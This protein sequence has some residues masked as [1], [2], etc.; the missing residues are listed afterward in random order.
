MVICIQQVA[1][2]VTS[3]IDLFFKS[4]VFDLCFVHKILSKLHY[5]LCHY[6]SNQGWKKNLGFLEK[7][8]GFFY[9]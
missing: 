1:A 5:L 6:I 9:F 3:L 7:F 8:L 2:P 4:A